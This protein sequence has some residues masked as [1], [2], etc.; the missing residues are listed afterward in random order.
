MSGP[1]LSYFDKLQRTNADD[2]AFYPLTTLAAALET[3][4]VR[5]C[6]DDRAHDH[7]RA[8]SVSMA[9]TIG[10]GMSPALAEALRRVLSDFDR[11]PTDEYLAEAGRIF[12]AALAERGM[13]IAPTSQAEAGAALERLGGLRSLTM[14]VERTLDRDEWAVRMRWWPADGPPPHHPIDRMGTG[15]TIASAIPAEA[16]DALFGV[17]S[18]YPDQPADR[19]VLE[20]PM[21]DERLAAIR[22]RHAGPHDEQCWGGHEDDGCDVTDLLA[23]LDEERETRDTAMGLY[24]SVAGKMDAADADAE[25]LAEALRHAMAECEEPTSCPEALAALAA[26]DEAAR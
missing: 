13:T 7:G 17:R 20:A 15:P 10:P 11:E 5:G 24:L 21:T 19:E 16:A 14:H 6:C 23:A 1:P 25:R 22:A 4:H 26:H 12:L 9:R 8:A 18:P 3:G 2:L